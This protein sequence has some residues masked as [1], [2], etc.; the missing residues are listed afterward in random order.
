MIATS[1]KTR[2]PVGGPWSS[3][4][5]RYDDSLERLAPL[6]VSGRETPSSTIGPL[7][8]R[9]PMAMS[10][11]R[12]G[13][14]GL[15]ALGNDRRRFCPLVE[16]VTPR[17]DPELPPCPGQSSSCTTCARS[18]YSPLADRE[19]SE[20]FCRDHVIRGR[21]ASA[22]LKVCSGQRRGVS[23]SLTQGLHSR[24]VSELK[25]MHH[26]LQLTRSAVQFVDGAANPS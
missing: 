7:G 26:P 2:L 25:T 3:F 17:H 24:H 18:L 19:L 5:Q 1:A 11:Q 15:I 20:H 23:A 4:G 10:G 13:P 22:V 14:S 16:R 8:R 9:S 6:A 12:T 21:S